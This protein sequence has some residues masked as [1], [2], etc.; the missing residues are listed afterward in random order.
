VG[1]HFVYVVL[2]MGLQCELGYLLLIGLL[3]WGGRA[4][5]PMKRFSGWSDFVLGL[6]I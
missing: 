5:Q 3:H 6:F 1:E 2:Q 4:Q